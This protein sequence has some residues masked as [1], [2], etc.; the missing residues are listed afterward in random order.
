LL[1][2]GAEGVIGQRVIK[3]VG[4]GLPGFRTAGW[5]AA[6]ARREGS[7]GGTILCHALV[8]SLSRPREQIETSQR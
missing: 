1:D 5:I 7:I 6:M 3:D 2:D 4:S 8:N